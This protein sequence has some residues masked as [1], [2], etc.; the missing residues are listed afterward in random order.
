VGTTDVAW[1]KGHAY[2]NKAPGL[3]FAVLP[4]YLVLEAAGQTSRSDPSF[5]LWALGLVGLVLPLTVLLLFVRAL[6][7][8]VQPGLGG[9]TAV[10]LGL[11]TLLL[12]FSTLFFAHT[13]STA[14][15]FAAFACLWLERR[16]PPR[17]ALVALAGLLAG[18]A[19]IVEYPVALVGLILF[20]YAVARHKLFPRALAYVSA[21]LAALV[22]L[23][24]YDWWAL[25][26]P[27]RLTYR[28]S[29]FVPGKTGR[30]VLVSDV[31]FSE[32]F[33]L[34]NL[35][36]FLGLLF[37]QWGLV[38]ASPVLALAAPGLY[39]LYR[40]GSR[41]EVFVIGA[42]LLA[43]MTYSASYY[44]PFGDTWAPRFLIPTIPFLALPLAC[45]LAEVP[46]LGAA[47]A[48]GSIA[49]TGAITLTN[50]MAAWDGHVLDRLLSPGLDA[51]ARTALEFAGVASSWD[52]IPFVAACGLA[53]AYVVVRVVRS[54]PEL[55]T[56]DG[57]AAVL[58]IGGWLLFAQLAPRTLLRVS[59][60][61]LV[62]SIVILA[63]V[64]AVVAPVLAIEASRR[65]IRS[66]PQ[67]P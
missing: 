35:E 11:G 21:G 4:A 51:H 9:A 29:V 42:I 20:P 7:E 58:A 49:L 27:F 59:D 67:S 32:L 48:A 46:L 1:Y 65:R 64:T 54:R 15:V 62:Q 66:V 38:T 34:P 56:E 13:L 43:F 19:V 16:G 6:V 40:R 28:Y 3:A 31:P 57:V 2:S 50:P 8:R 26:S 41:G 18:L 24:L 52:S 33:H 36:G 44:A 14:L 63:F 61:S 25:G 60:E 22:P 5:V 10:T 39:L 12:P 53:T 47:L 23:A 17:L 37:S 55:R 45:A 30:D